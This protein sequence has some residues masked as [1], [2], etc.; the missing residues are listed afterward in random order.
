VTLYKSTVG[1]VRAI[2]DAYLLLLSPCLRIGVGEKSA[3]EQ[4]ELIKE[5]ILEDG[6]NTVLIPI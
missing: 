6:N 1:F 4:L 2:A 5:D 3:E